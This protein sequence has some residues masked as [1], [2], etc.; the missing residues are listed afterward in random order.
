M[1]WAGRALATVMADFGAKQAD[2]EHQDAEIVLA[3]PL[4]GWMK[5]TNTNAARKVLLF[6]R[7]G[8]SFVDKAAKAQA[9][10]AVAAIIYNNEDGGATRM[11]I[12]DDE[13]A[14][15]QA[16][17]V[18]I[19]VVSISQADGTQ[20]AAAIKAGRTTITVQGTFSEF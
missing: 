17:T 6:V 12:G 8:V 2:R 15:K 19:P 3:E 14:H 7:G 20:L 10:G 13:Q 16:A 11:G 18:K 5:L 1:E 9:A 4:E